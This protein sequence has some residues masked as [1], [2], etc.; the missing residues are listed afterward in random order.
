MNLNQMDALS[1]QKSFSTESQCRAFLVKLR[2]PQ[3]FICPNCQHDDAI[4]LAPRQLFQCRLCKHQT[5]VTAGTIF[6]KT[7][8]PLTC[9]FWIIF[10]IVHDKGGVSANSLASQLNRPYKTIWHVLHKLRYAMNRRDEGITLGGLIELD[11]ATLG[12]EARRS[13]RSSDL[14]LVT[15]KRKELK[16]K[17]YG[18]KSKKSRKRKTVI[19]VLVMAEAERFHIGN[20]AMKAV[21]R[22][23]YDEI[24]DFVETR[25]EGKQRFK[26]DARQCHWK[27]RSMGHEFEP[28]KSSTEIYEEHLP[29]VHRTIS[30]LKH[31]LMGTY[32]GVSV[33]HLQS[34]LAEFVFRFI[35]REKILSMHESLLR[36]CLFAL[37]MTYAEL[38]L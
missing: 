30:L 5:S 35:R 21:E 32:H 10:Q 18:R 25:T 27:I 33:K 13:T 8:L 2:W 29:V 15:K 3:G 22:V 36:A 9:W 16:K 7:H 28:K 6:H 19:E 11:E 20:V 1:F 34:Y 12:P 17:P 4:Y 37:P 31:F 26:T 23:N 38:K 14:R 24:G